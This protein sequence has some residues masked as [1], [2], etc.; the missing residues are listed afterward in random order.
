MQD[1][2]ESNVIKTE[3]LVAKQDDTTEQLTDE[4]ETEETSAEQEN[5]TE[6]LT[7][8]IKTEEIS[9]E[10]DF[11]AEL[12]KSENPYSLLKSSDALTNNIE[13][14]NKLDSEEMREFAIRVVLDCPAVKLAQYS[15]IVSML[16]SDKDS[17]SSW[18]ESNDDATST[19][20]E[21]AENFL[22]KLEAALQVRSVVFAILDPN[23]LSTYSL[24]TYIESFR[25][26]DDLALSLIKDQEILFTERLALTTPTEELSKLSMQLNSI[27]RDT[28]LVRQINIA[29][30]LRRDVTRLLLSN[31]PEDFFLSREFNPTTYPKFPN[32]LNQLLKNEEEKIG[33]RLSEIKSPEVSNKI[34]S[35]LENLNSIDA[36]KLIAVTLSSKKT[37][38][39]QSSSDAKE[40]DV[41]DIQNATY[42][43]TLFKRSKK[44]SDQVDGTNL[45][46]QMPKEEILRDE[47][48][49]KSCCEKY[50]TL[51]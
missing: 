40:V 37:E 24:L 19:S 46:A 5:V 22:M 35:Y 50:C 45:V 36:F 6:Q 49:E 1:K 3:E 38:E 13:K 39:N 48:D 25:E 43:N 31:K 16:L 2:I 33:T 11:F 32:L 12:L 18:N 9:A 15:L 20:N 17:D 29:F 47:K 41:V 42:P 21:D 26:F 34:Q 23:H 4:T 51:F 30:S 14:L 27:F 10:Q 44:T 28:D 7:D 8:E